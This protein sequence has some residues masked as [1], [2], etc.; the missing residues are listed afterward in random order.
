M[1]ENVNSINNI[2]GVISN[3]SSESLIS[4]NSLLT[5][6]NYI[7]S[8]E[9]F[10]QY[11][12]HFLHIMND[13]KDSLQ[14]INDLSYRQIHHMQRD[15]SNSVPKCQ[16][17]FTSKSLGLKYNYDTIALAAEMQVAYL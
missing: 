15:P 3:T 4:I 7:S 16:L 6:L 14:Y 11:K 5:S 8:Y 13:I 10:L 17:E 2:L 1:E 12:T 9:S